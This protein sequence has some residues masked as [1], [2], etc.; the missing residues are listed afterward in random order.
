MGDLPTAVAAEHV[1]MVVSGQAEALAAGLLFDRVQVVNGRHVEQLAGQQPDRWIL[2]WEGY[3][4]PGVLDEVAM[5]SNCGVRASVCV[6][7]GDGTLRQ[8][9]PNLMVAA[10]VPA[11]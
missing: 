6:L 7:N 5:R 3:N 4:L 11:E 8:I 2:T 9:W 1:V 10:G